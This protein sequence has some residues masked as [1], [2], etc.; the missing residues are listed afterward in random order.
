MTLSNQSANSLLIVRSYTMR[1]S[2]FRAEK[3]M[4]HLYKEGVTIICFAEPSRQ[5]KIHTGA[6]FPFFLLL[7]LFIFKFTKRAVSSRGIIT[8]LLVRV[9]RYTS[10]KV[11]RESWGGGGGNNSSATPSFRRPSIDIGQREFI[12]IWRVDLGPC[13]LLPQFAPFPFT[14]LLVLVLGP[15]LGI[16]LSPYTL[17]ITPLS[18]S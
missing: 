10:C 15:V 6:G 8:R 7:S 1:I 11:Q 2:A 17:P 18:C 9:D 3:R 4:R 13:S 16:G 14:C 12:K 5:L